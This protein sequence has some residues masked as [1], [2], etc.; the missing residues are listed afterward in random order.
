M[1][2]IIVC[3][4]LSRVLVDKFV[5][6][7]GSDLLI[8]LDSVTHYYLPARVA[9]CLLTHLLA[10]S[11]VLGCLSTTF[12]CRAV[13]LIWLV[14]SRSGGWLRVNRHE[15]IDCGATFPIWTTGS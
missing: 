11:S 6:C 3:S 13:G 5:I 9:Y 10:A 1:V 4:L 8:P 12:R 15:R 2:P 7:V 14:L